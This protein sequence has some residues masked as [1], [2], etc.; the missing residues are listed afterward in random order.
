MKNLKLAAL[1]LFATVAVNAQDLKNNEVPRD[2]RLNFEKEFVNATDIEWEKQND[3]YK[4]EFDIARK[5][6]E[7]WYD[8]SG[9]TIKTE[10]ELNE[11]ELPQAIKS[12]ISTSYSSFKIEDIEMKEEAGKITYEVELKK[13]WN[14]EKM[15]IFDEIGSIIK[16]YED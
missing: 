10:K 1:T 2:L 13:G 12:K 3:L 9:K 7:I 15:L 5:E 14:N 16:E 6:N 4:V 11:A 8:A